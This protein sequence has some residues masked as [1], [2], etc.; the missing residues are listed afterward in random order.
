MKA[1]LADISRIWQSLT[2]RVRSANRY[3]VRRWLDMAFLGAVSGIVCLVF[4][5]WLKAI[6]APVLALLHD[7]PAWLAWAVSVLAHV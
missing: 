1:L 5:P 7:R 2:G 6:T 4:A 3:I